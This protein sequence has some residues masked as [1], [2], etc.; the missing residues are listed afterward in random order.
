M[1][2]RNPLLQ[3]ARRLAAIGCAVLVLSLGICAASP[4]LHHRWHDVTG[5]ACGPVCAVVMFASGVVLALAAVVA[6]PR[7]VCVE[8]LPRILIGSFVAVPRFRLLPERGP[9]GR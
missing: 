1:P 2:T 9:P 5:T 8:T 3:Y 6:A 4:E 7:A